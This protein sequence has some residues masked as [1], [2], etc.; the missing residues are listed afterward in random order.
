MASSFDEL[1]VE[2]GDAPLDR[3]DLDP[4]P[5]QQLKRWIDQAAAAGVVEPNAFVL[6]TAGADGQPSGR[7]VLLKDLGPAGLTFYTNYESRKGQELAHNPQATAVFLWTPIRRQVRVEGPVDKVP[8]EV[9]DAYFASRPPE[10][11]LAS[12]ASPQ[13]QV[14]ESREALEAL[15]EE[16]RARFPAGDVP[17]PAHW[18]G[19]L[20]APHYFEFWQGREA[21]YHDRF[22]YRLESGTWRIERLAP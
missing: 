1:R 6:A 5:V 2:Y 10:A 15:L 17:R 19:Y 9:S 14:V 20:L 16:L 11:R 21:R 4:D 3:A 13:S 22:R 7:T 18:G 12:A 8:E